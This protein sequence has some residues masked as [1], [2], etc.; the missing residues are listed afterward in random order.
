MEKGCVQVY[1]GDGK[2]K[3][4]AMLGLAVRASGANLRVYIGQF[5]KS[6]E[7]HEV[8]VIRNFLPNVS[9]ELYGLGCAIERKL[10]EED[11]QAAKKGLK[12]AREAIF[13]GKY[14][15]VMLDEINIA[16]YLKLLDTSSVLE[17]MKTKPTNVELILTG[18]FAPDEIV[19]AADLVTEMAEIKHY[20]ANGVLARDG[21]ER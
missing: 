13:S 16:I 20:Y 14:D 7:Y 4:T 18:R 2:G 10:T 19:S 8:E 6:M 11:V 1:T 15:I 5:V 12:K 3:T 17:L 21:I 9:I